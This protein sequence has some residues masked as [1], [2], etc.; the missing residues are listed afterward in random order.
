MPRKGTLNNILYVNEAF[1]SVDTMF[2]SEIKHSGC[3]KYVF[4][5][6][7]DIDFTRLDSGTGVP[8][9]T[10]STLYAIPL[11]KPEKAIIQNFD[12]T[13]SPLFQKMSTLVSETKQLALLRDELL[14]LLMN[15][16]VSVKQ[17]NNDL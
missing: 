2:Y 17:L 15:S 5:S 13:I 12:D 10:S 9:M 14:P 3:A 8:S 4:Y 6:I 7:K 11:I 16:Q 1:W